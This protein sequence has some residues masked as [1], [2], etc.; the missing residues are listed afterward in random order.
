MC[1]SSYSQVVMHGLDAYVYYICY[2]PL[3]PVCAW[4]WCSSQQMVISVNS[5]Q[6]LSAVLD[7]LIV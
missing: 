2:W 4:W 5:N 7:T 1:Y 6:E 3:V